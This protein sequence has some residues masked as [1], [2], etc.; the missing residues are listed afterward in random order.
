MIV[1]EHLFG[2]DPCFDKPREQTVETLGDVFEVPWIKEHG[3][4]NVIIYQNYVMNEMRV[5][6]HL[7]NEDGT[8]AN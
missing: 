2:P 1:R 6:A 7:F 8:P 3:E 4:G 5:L